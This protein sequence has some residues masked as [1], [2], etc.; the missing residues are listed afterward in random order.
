V[1]NERNLFPPP[2]P[3]PPLC[4]LP[5]IF[6]SS[7]LFLMILVVALVTPRGMLNAL[8]PE[9]STSATSLDA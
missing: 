4:L 8:S 6:L 7:V 5:S 3:S 2:P 1:K 9:T